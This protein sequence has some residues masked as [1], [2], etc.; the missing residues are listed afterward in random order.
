[1][2]LLPE[3][4]GASRRATGAR[5]A[6][7]ALLLSGAVLVGAL[8]VA[9]PGALS[10]LLLHTGEPPV[11]PDARVAPLREP[12]VVIDPGGYTFLATAEGAPVRWD[13][14]RPVHVVL[15]AQGMPAGGE[16]LVRDALDEVGAASGLVMVVDGYT[17][18][19][20][21]GERPLVDRRRYGD[22]WAPVLVAWSDEAEF[23]ELA[24]SLGVAGPAEWSG[25]G[26]TRFV[27][28]SLVLDRA[29]FADAVVADLGRRQAGAVVRHELGHLV[30]L[31]HASDPF[32]LMAPTYASVE[33]FSLADLAG[34]SALGG[35]PCATSGGRDHLSPP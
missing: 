34:L 27:S 32:A 20:P 18:E 26:P 22:R 11:P 9:A 24:G 33:A 8:V 29:W 5:S 17:D 25:G 3:C 12:P 30:G 35:G 2:S 28:G 10:G 13:P 21:T 16:Q 31:G 14:C 7:V 1:M 4:V 6:V 15:R 23:P 19:P